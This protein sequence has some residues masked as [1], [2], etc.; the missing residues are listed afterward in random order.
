MIYRAELD[1]LRKMLKKFRLQS[2]VLAPGEALPEEFSPA[3]RK[4]FGRD[5]EYDRLFLAVA[6]RTEGQVIYLVSDGVRC[7]YAFMKLP[8]D[9]GLLM[10]GPYYTEV[11]REQ[12]VAALSAR[13]SLSAE[14][15]AQLRHLMA[16]VPVLAGEGILT[17][18]LQA[19]GETVWGETEMIRILDIDREFEGVF[20]FAEEKIGA[21]ADEQLL[22]NMQLMETRYA[23]ENELMRIVSNGLVMQ[24]DQMMFHFSDFHFAQRSGDPLYSFKHYCIVCNTLLRKAAEQGGVHPLYLDRMSSDFA[25]KIESLRAVSEGET[26]IGD[27]IRTYSR[28]VRKHATAGYSGLVQKTVT[29]IDADPAGDLSLRTVAAA[30]KVTASYLS[31]QFK[32]ETGQ[33]LTDYVN[34]KRIHHA[35]HLLQTTR[36]QVQTIAQRCGFQDPNYFV[37]LFKKK[38]GVTPAQYR[39]HSSAE[40]GETQK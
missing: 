16:E 5:S 37:R 32:K 10:I 35:I 33:T 23:N 24:A 20:S 31:A 17:R 8:A 18:A 11:L 29:Y 34:E 40:R 21:T 26:L 12:D 25:W 6:S 7:R 19:L 4:F 9:D 14:R 39:R 36:L 13:F 28:L 1:F 3:F 22:L 30:Q 27:M 38:T 2:F 15:A